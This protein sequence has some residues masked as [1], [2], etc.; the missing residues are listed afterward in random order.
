M[1]RAL[2]LEHLRK[3]NEDI[4]NAHVRIDR[5]CELVARLQEHGHDPTMAESV[6]QTMRDSLAAMEEH[7]RLIVSEL[8]R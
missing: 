1:D 2:E 7:H 8:S 5:Q 4:A 6:L 3:A